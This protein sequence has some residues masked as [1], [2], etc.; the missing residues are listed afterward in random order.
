MKGA[1]VG[2]SRRA[3]SIRTRPRLSAEGAALLSSLGALGKVRQLEKLQSDLRDAPVPASR[4][5]LT[6]GDAP[7]SGLVVGDGAQGTAQAVVPARSLLGELMQ[8]LLRSRDRACGGAERGDAASSCWSGRRSR[9]IGGRKA[10]TGPLARLRVTLRPD[11][12]LT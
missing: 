6:I 5:P 10:T 1:A 4:T 2:S 8:A 7:S 3:A 9:R 11:S 12:R